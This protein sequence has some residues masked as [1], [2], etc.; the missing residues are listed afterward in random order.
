MPS[1]GA[2]GPPYRASIPRVNLCRVDPRRCGQAGLG[3]IA[4]YRCNSAELRC[5]TAVGV[6]KSG[7]I[8]PNVW[9]RSGQSKP[10]V[11]PCMASG[12][13][14]GR[15][16][17]ESARGDGGFWGHTAQGQRFATLVTGPWHGGGGGFSGGN[18]RFQPTALR[19]HG[20]SPFESSQRCFRV[21][22]NLTGECGTVLARPKNLQRSCTFPAREC[23]RGRDL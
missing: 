17:A 1:E 19:F 5:L 11:R 2:P 10:I 8:G 18:D 6:S 23:G 15:N 7:R 14:T 21:G 12:A 9:K 16:M 3:T 13:Q 20:R 22:N 4:G